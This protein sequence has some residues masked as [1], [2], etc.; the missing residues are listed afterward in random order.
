MLKKTNEAKLD[1][2][3]F[4][5]HDFGCWNTTIPIPGSIVTTSIVESLAPTNNDNSNY[6]TM[7]L[8]RLLNG[9]DHAKI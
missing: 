8:L 9:L 4:N 5:S 7:S 1:K 2:N 3:V 6:G